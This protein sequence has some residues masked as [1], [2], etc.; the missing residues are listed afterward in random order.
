MPT[1][2]LDVPGAVLIFL[3]AIAAFLTALALPAMAA[4]KQPTAPTRYR[5]IAPPT[6]LIILALIIAPLL[7]QPWSAFVA[8]ALTFAALGDLLHNLLRAL[9]VERFGNLAAAPLWLRYSY[10]AIASPML[11]LL[12]RRIGHAWSLP[13]GDAPSRAAPG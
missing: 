7:Q 6:F 10:A 2:D 5:L 3:G 8:G 13:P 1:P 12:G 11:T 4:V 9:A